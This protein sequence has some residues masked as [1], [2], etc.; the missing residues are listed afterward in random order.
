MKDTQEEWAK[1]CKQASTEQ[2]PQR[3]MILV[4]RILKLF[5]GKLGSST[6]SEPIHRR[7][8]SNH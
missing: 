3:L 1:L 2:D 4:R 7:G 5:D 6:H 8:S